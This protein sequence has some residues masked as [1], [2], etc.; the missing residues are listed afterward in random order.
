MVKWVTTSVAVTM[1]ALAGFTATTYTKTVGDL[2]WSY[3]LSRA[4]T[5]TVTGVTPVPEEL[6]LPSALNGYP[7]VAVGASSFQGLGGLKKVVVS[8]SVTSIGAGAFGKCTS[9]GEVMF[10]DGV[11]SFGG[12]HQMTS[13]YDQEGVFNGCTSLSNVVF[14]A[15]L[16]TIGGH[17]FANCT[18]LAR[19]VLPNN[20]ETVANNCFY[21]YTSKRCGKGAVF[22]CPAT[23]VTQPSEQLLVILTLPCWL[24][25]NGPRLDFA[26]RCNPFTFYV[27]M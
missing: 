2:T 7:V 20:V 27:R 10:G 11:Q 3:T 6:E 15:G 19:V 13:S 5:A 12:S 22:Q 26:N 21:G 24:D 23:A 14:G 16:K 25:D 18:K 17:A 8:D 4:N 1:L 9:L